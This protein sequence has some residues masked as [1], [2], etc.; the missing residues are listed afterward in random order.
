MPLQT[1]ITAAKTVSRANAAL[2]GPPERI[3]E[4]ISA[5]SITVT[6][7]A[8]TREPKGSPTRAATTSAWWTAA[9]TV[10]ASSTTS[11]RSTGVPS[12]SARPMTVAARSAAARAGKAQAQMGIFSIFAAMAARLGQN[13]RCWNRAGR[14]RGGAR[15]PGPALPVRSYA[16]A[17]AGGL[18]IQ[19]TAVAAN[20]TPIITGQNAA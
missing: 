2:S 13:G 16:Q 14:K 17:R 15:E 1:I 6:A 9:K 20:P 5:T 18:A 7:T 19:F 10:P 11:S 3:S 12:A 4:T 8:R